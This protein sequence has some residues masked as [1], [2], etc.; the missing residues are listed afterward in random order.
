MH[1]AD[2]TLANQVCT[3]TAVASAAGLVYAVARARKHATPRTLA[4]AGAGAAVVFVAQMIDVP[5]G[6]VPVHMV[7]AP[8]L[9]ALSGP[10]L[11][12]LAMTLV[13]AVQALALHDGGVS[14]LGANVFNMGV[15]GVGVATLCIDAV[16][17]RIGTR[18]GRLIGVALASAASMSVAVMAMSAELALPGGSRE[19]FAAAIAAHAP[20]AAFETLATVA[21]VAALA[22]FP[23]CAG[24]AGVERAGE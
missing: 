16:N 12:L 17:A 10:A 8:F 20:F 14:A 21:V 11:A 5:F 23:V 4:R 19:V 15:V 1:L 6:A 9:V 2:G 3:A 22:P 7:G 24:E 13:L 18:A